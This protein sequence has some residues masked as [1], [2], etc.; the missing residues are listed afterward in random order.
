MAN[1]RPHAIRSRARSADRA[2]IERT[3]TETVVSKWSGDLVL[4]DARQ[5]CAPPADDPDAYGAPSGAEAST[6]LDDE[7]PF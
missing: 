6:R 3:I 4:F 5:S 1:E 2:G 7:I